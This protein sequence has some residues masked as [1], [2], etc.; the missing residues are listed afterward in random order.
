LIVLD[1]KHPKNMVAGT[2]QKLFEYDAYGRYRLSE[3]GAELEQVLLAIED[4]RLIVL[5]LL[6]PFL[7]HG[8]GVPGRSI[9]AWAWLRKLADQTGAAVVVT[10]DGPKKLQSMWRKGIRLAVER[11]PLAEGAK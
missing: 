4:L 8:F 7:P 11:R 2:N 3:A 10:L 5:S 9:P 6:W 1:P